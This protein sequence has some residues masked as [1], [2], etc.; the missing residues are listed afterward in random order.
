[1]VPQ[2]GLAA[3]LPRVLQVLAAPATLAEYGARLAAADAALRWEELLPDL[4][5]LAASSPSPASAAPAA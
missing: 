2:T 5:A 1:L 4:E 3:L